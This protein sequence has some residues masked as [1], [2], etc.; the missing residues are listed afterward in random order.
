MR[1]SYSKPGPD[2]LEQ[3]HIDFTLNSKEHHF[4]KISVDRSGLTN[5]LQRLSHKDSILRSVDLNNRAYSQYATGVMT[6][7]TFPTLPNLLKVPYYSKILT[8]ELKVVPVRGTYDTYYFLP[9]S[10]NLQ[11]TNLTNN[12]GGAIVQ[13]GTNSAE[14]GN[15]VVD[16]INGD[17]TTYSYDVSGYI[18]ALIQS[19]L[20][21]SYALVNPPEY[22][23]GLLL[24]PPAPATY[25]QFS[26]VV[27]GN[28][29]QPQ[30]FKT[31]LILNYLTIQ[32]K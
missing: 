26:R 7:M 14:G 31:I 30:N 22:N 1:L 6:K 2:T 13:P 27:I 16:Y 9:P 17:N 32:P 3:N 23:Y 19:P 8:A 29:N 20:A 5:G 15:L 21:S 4:N 24:V 10:L 18:K 11:N 28:Q 25:T 12:F